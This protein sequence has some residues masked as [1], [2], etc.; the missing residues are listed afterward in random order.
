[1]GLFSKRQVTPGAPIDSPRGSRIQAA[2]PKVRTA[3]DGRDVL[4]N[5]PDGWEVDQPWLWFTGPAGGG[6]GPFGNPLVPSDGDP[7]GLSNQAG[8]SRCTSIICDTISGLPWKVFRGEYTELP[9]PAWLIDP[10]ST[11]VDG[12]VVD[13][14]QVWEARLSA[15]EFWANWICAALWFGDGYVYA[16]VRDSNGQPQPPLWQLH[17]ADV[18]IDGGDYWE[19]GRRP[20]DYRSA[21]RRPRA[22]LR[23]PRRP[24]PGRRRATRALRSPCNG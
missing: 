6:L 2:G 3:T 23:G 9:T 16:P 20:G 24:A 14:G 18:V 8:V 7:F 1:M 15:V 22:D 11:R 10:Q 4:L 12:R 17:P 13:P 5:T 19:R 21:P